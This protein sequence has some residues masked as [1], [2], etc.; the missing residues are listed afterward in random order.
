[1]KHKPNEMAG[2]VRAR[3]VTGALDTPHRTAQSHLHIKFSENPTQN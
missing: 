2:C 1:M 3:Q